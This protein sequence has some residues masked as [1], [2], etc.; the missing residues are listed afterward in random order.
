MKHFKLGLYSFNID[1]DVL[2]LESGERKEFSRDGLPDNLKPL[3]D[4]V[5][6]QEI[7][8][9]PIFINFKETDDDMVVSGFITQ[10]TKTTF[11][12][13]VVSSNILT[14]EYNSLNNKIGFTYYVI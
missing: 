10:T 7:I 14:I 13:P 9:K 11:K 4:I 6:K 12:I 8:E 2:G 3:F 1:G 5:S